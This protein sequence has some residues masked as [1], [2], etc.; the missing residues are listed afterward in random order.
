MEYSESESDTD[1][2]MPELVE[3][4]NDLEHHHHLGGM[5][6]GNF[7]GNTGNIIINPGNAGNFGG[8]TGNIIINPGN[9]GNEGNE[10]NEGNAGDGGSVVTC[11]T[12]N[13]NYKPNLI[14]TEY[15]D[16]TIC[17]Y[18]LFWLHFDENVRQRVDGVYG[19]T[20]VEFILAYKDSH[21]PNTCNISNACFLCHAINNIPMTN[22]IGGEVLYQIN[23]STQE[24]S[25]IN[26]MNKYDIDI[27][28]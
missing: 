12:C 4:D 26:P 9:A 20:I 8:N 27:E 17:W 13:K 18:C 11:N 15:T 21:D 28:I 22:I 2:S 14:A 23:T 10:G 25:K 5:Y 6:A 1:S 19:M 3:Q 16:D 24:T 7:G